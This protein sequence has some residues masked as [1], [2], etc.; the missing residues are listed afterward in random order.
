MI[1]ALRQRFRATAKAELERSLA[2]PLKH[3]S[4]DD[5]KA[6][7]VMLDAMVNKLLHALPH[8]R[9]GKADRRTDRGIRFA[10]IALELLNDCF[11][12]I[13]KV[14]GA[15]LLAHEGHS[16]MPGWVKQLNPQFWERFTTIFVGYLAKYRPYRRFSETGGVEPC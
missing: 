16:L 12:G 15:V 4:D 8:C 2:K 1:T 14:H 7:E 3:L 13:I 5:R 10:P 11:G 9:F 6:L